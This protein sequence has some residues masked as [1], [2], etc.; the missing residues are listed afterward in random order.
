MKKDCGFLEVWGPSFY[1]FSG[2][3]HPGNLRDDASGERTPKP[4]PRSV[5]PNDV[6]NVQSTSLEEHPKHAILQLSSIR[7]IK[8]NMRWFLMLLE[9]LIIRMGLGPL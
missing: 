1:I 6:R 8:I 2:L 4:Q 3:A 5:H 7:T 9:S